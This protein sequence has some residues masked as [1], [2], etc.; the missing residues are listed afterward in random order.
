MDYKSLLIYMDD[1]LMIFM[2]KQLLIKGQKMYEKKI[3]PKN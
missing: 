3:N 1:F 2:P